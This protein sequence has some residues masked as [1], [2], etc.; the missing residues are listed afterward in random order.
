MAETTQY[1]TVGIGQER[2][3]VPVSRV[4]EILDVCPIAALPHAPPDLLGIIDVRGQGVPVVDMRLRMGFPAAADTR[5]TRIVVLTVTGGQERV[6]GLKAD[7]VFEVTALDSEDLDP[8]PD[9]GVR[10]RSELIAGVGRRKG[11]FVTVLDLN[12]MFASDKVPA[13]P[14]SIKSPPPFVAA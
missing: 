14:A 6:I 8:A 2:F 10:W 1:V 9:V 12:R 5:D 4:R 3:A 13:D 11:A 7:K